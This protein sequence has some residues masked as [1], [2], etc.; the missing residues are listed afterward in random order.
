[1]KI[2]LIVWILTGGQVERHEQIMPN[3]EECRSLAYFI[4]DRVWEIDCVKVW[5]S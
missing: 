5:E 1:M 3:L 4:A 2:L